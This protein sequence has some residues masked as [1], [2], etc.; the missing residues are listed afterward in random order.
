MFDYAPMSVATGVPGVI[1]GK[2]QARRA[3]EKDCGLN[4]PDATGFPA[5]LEHVPP[6]GGRL[7]AGRAEA[8]LVPNLEAFRCLASRLCG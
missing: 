4:S 7:R 8:G 1:R 5:P 3:A 6:P 2:V